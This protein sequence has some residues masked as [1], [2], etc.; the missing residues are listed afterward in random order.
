MSIHCPQ[1]LVVQGPKQPAPLN[2][3]L[4]VPGL[5]QDKPT[6]YMTLC[7][8]SPFH[9]GACLPPFRSSCLVRGS[10]GG[11]GQARPVPSSMTLNRPSAPRPSPGSLAASVPCHQAGFPSPPKPPGTYTPRGN[12]HILE[13]RSSEIGVI[14]CPP[15]LPGTG[16]IHASLVEIIPLTL[17]HVPP[18]SPPSWAAP[19]P[20]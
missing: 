18:C 13:D 7:P 5:K 8:P 14:T 9:W 12:H 20:A 2:H 19:W 11:T 3:P 4:Y 16:A 17:A 6:S 15:M 1:T 10:D